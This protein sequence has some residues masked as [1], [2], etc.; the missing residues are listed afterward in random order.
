MGLAKLF[1]ILLFPLGVLQILE[2]TNIFSIDLG[3]NV[4]LV[5]AIMMIL[6]QIMIL[7]VVKRDS[8]NYSFMNVVSFIIFAGFAAYYIITSMINFGMWQHTPII[9]GVMM[10]LEGLYV[11]H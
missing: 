11:M 8:T 7:L 9:L 6:V 3:V 1:A 5:G 10:F 2:S 4:A